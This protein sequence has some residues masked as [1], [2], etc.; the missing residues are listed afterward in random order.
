MCDVIEVAGKLACETTALAPEV[1]GSVIGASEDGSYV[2]FVSKAALA[3]RAGSEKTISMSITTTV[4]AWEPR[5]H[6]HAIRQET[7]KKVMTG[8]KTSSDLTAR[9]SPNGKWL[10]FM[11]R[12]E[13]HRL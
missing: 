4:R 11:S 6:R 8:R 13:P 10:A 5:N 7:T 1:Q 3:P 2:Y 9:V 12:Q